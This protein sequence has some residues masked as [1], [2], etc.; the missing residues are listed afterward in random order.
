MGLRERD[1]E[2][3]ERVIQGHHLETTV[4]GKDHEQERWSG[5][6][7]AGTSR[8]SLV[9]RH[10]T[11]PSRILGAKASGS[12]LL[13]PFD[14]CKYFNAI[15]AKK[16]RFSAFIITYL[17]FETSCWEKWFISPG[18]SKSFASIG[19]HDLCFRDPLPNRTR[20]SVRGAVRQFPLIC[21][22]CLTH[23]CFCREIRAVVCH[24]RCSWPFPLVRLNPH[25]DCISF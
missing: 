25:S 7:W 24:S 1:K 10:Q 17:T 18:N 4:P 19:R 8:R 2:R 20:L 22:S 5:G 6:R 14:S 11:E 16:N 21:R 9:L 12:C 13:N 3:C 15:S 23:L